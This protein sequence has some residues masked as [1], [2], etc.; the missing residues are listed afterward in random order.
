[1]SK[2]VGDGIF[3]L[4]H[5]GKLNTRVLWFF[6]KNCRIVA[7]QALRNKSQTLPRRDI[8]I[9]LQRMNDWQRRVER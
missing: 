7:V 3:E 6:A 1:M 9:A 2:S 5:V 4:R 8:R